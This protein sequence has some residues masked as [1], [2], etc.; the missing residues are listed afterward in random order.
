MG[1]GWRN[2]FYATGVPGWVASAPE[3]EVADLK[4]QA[5]QLKAQLDAVQKRIEEMSSK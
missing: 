2:R 1:R 3:Q 5:D 4:V